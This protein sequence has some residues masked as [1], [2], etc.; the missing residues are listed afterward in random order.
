GLALPEGADLSEFGDRLRDALGSG[1][2]VVHVQVGGDGK[3]AFLA[4]VT[5]DWIGR[6]VKAGDLVRVASRATGSGGGGR[7]HLAQGG[8]GEEGSVA[9]ALE[10]V[11]RRVADAV[12]A[13]A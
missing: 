6:G 1:V 5:D 4:V 10:E 9:G 12:K 13:G 3:Q 11:E 7:P 2:A 8:V